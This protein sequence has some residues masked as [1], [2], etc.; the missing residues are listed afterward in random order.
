MATNEQIIWQF[1]KAQ[2]LSDAGV[3]GLMGN[4]YAESGLNPKNMQNVYEKKLGYT[5]ETYTAAVDS[6]KYKK[7]IKDSVGYGL[8]Q[9][10]FWSRKQGLLSL[11]QQKNKSVG[12]LQIQLEFLMIELSQSFS[13]LLKMLK[14]TNSVKEASDA[15][16]LQF[17]RPADQSEA[18]KTKRANYSQQYYNKYKTQQL[19]Q[20]QSKMKYNENNKPLS[21]IMTNSSCYISTT[22]M[23]P[24]GVLWHST[25]VNNPTLKRYVQPGNKDT[26]RAE[27]IKIL[28]TNLYNNDLNHMTYKIGLNAWIGKLADDSVAAIQTLPWNYKPWGCGTGSKGSC[29]NGWIQF[30]ICEDNLA[31]KEYFEKIY[32]EGCELTAYLCKMY[33]IDPFGTITING[34]KVPTILCHADSYRLG[35]GSNHADILHWFGKYG[36]TMDNVR[37]DVAA[38]INANPEVKPGV[39]EEE[40][41]VTQEQFNNMM[42]VWIAEQAKK[43]PSSWSAASREWGERNGLIQGDE[44]GNKSYKKLMTRE[45]FIEVLYR[46][47]HRYLVG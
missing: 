3:A 46:A 14:S 42:N 20:Q 41:E 40:E 31:N 17:E 39:E 24:V 43:A 33:N 4:L 27:M 44:A 29:N 35:M 7:F 5:D 18:M 10:T 11:A 19:P 22:T 2:G 37:A 36:K 21:C 28:G 38:L 1:L 47:L 12:D 34:V 6:G 9:W 25:G 8:A 32:K 30:E 13:S 26:N 23:T 45:E 15:V 16:L